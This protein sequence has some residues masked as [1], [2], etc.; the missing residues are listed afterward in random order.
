MVEIWSPEIPFDED[1]VGRVTPRQPGVYR[2][3]Q[4]EAYPRYRDRTRV[5]KIGMSRTDLRSEIWNHFRR[6]AAANRLSRIR[7]NAAVVITVE[8]AVTSAVDAVEIERQLLREFE[9]RHWDLP[10]LNSTRGYARGEDMHFGAD[11]SGSGQ[12]MTAEAKEEACR[13]R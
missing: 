1:A 3:L 9:D 13:R 6:H 4:S 12:D 10:L 2:F 11:S 7:R 8:F 5:L